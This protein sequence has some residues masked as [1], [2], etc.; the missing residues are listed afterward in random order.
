MQRVLTIGATPA[1]CCCLSRASRELERVERGV[2]PHACGTLITRTHNCFHLVLCGFQTFLTL[3]L[4]GRVC[5]SSYSYS[6]SRGGCNRVTAFVCPL[7][8]PLHGIPVPVPVLQGAP[9][10]STVQAALRILLLRPSVSKSSR[11][12]SSFLRLLQQHRATRTSPRLHH[13]R[14]LPA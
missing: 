11:M 3:F 2:Y 8:Q 14:M 12:T 7:D 13:Q 4:L 6:V 9:L 10:G 5:H 1:G